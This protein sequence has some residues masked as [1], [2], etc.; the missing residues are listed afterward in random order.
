MHEVGLPVRP[1]IQVGPVLLDP[2]RPGQIDQLDGR[3]HGAMV[4]VFY[5]Q[6]NYE[7]LIESAAYGVTHIGL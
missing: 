4:E 6:L 2:A 5:E 7:M 1:G 3:K